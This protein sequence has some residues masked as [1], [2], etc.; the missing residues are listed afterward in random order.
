MPKDLEGFESPRTFIE[1]RGI[2]GGEKTDSNMPVKTPPR[3]RLPVRNFETKKFD[4]DEKLMVDIARATGISNPSRNWA[5]DVHSI[6]VYVLSDEVVGENGVVFLERALYTQRGRLCGSVA[7]QEHADQ[8][9]DIRAYAKNKTI[10][11]LPQAREVPC[12]PDCPMWKEPGQK[13]DCRWRAVVSVQLQQSPVFPSPSRHR[14]GSFNSIKAMITSLNA[15]SA[16]TGGVLMG[17]PLLFRQERIDVRDG[18]GK[19]RRIPVM[20]FDFAGT[21]A[22]LRAAAVREVT[23]RNVLKNAHGGDLGPSGMSLAATELGDGQVLDMVPEYRAEDETQAR[24]LS[25]EASELVSEV[26]ELFHKLGYTPRNRQLMED[27]HKGDLEAMAEELRRLA[28]QDFD[29]APGEPGDEEEQA[30]AEDDDEE[31]IEDL[32][33]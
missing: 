10:K 18:E 9:V 2:R 20:V 12:T 7:G 33:E 17:I 6:P 1:Y 23:S 4:I 22:E 29:P 25:E 19:N 16:V 28:P 13:S 11:Q 31:D 8:R 5:S 21:I 27:K 32:F 3:V 14:T 30:S 15:I 24:E 26:A